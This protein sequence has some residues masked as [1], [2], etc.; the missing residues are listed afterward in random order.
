MEMSNQVLMLC[1]L[2]SRLYIDII[3]P[4][5]SGVPKIGLTLILEVIKSEL[6]Y[7]VI[8]ATRCSYFFRQING[9]MPKCVAVGHG[10][11]DQNDF[12]VGQKICIAER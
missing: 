10:A 2:E 11:A 5:V 12:I 6:E 7:M 3:G 8:N 9:H 1:R 4:L